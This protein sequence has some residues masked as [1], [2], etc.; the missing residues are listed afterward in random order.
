MVT[1]EPE[2]AQ[3]EDEPTPP[4]PVEDVGDRV[5]RL[6]ARFNALTSDRQKW[7]R[8][9]IDKPEDALNHVK[10]NQH[11]TD[12]RDWFTALVAGPPEDQDAIRARVGVDAQA[13]AAAMDDVGVFERMAVREP[14]Q[15]ELTAA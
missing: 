8:A 11:W 2:P 12:V 5:S 10:N 7:C 13:A 15:E 1:A 14:D 6:V 3:P 9:R 4:P